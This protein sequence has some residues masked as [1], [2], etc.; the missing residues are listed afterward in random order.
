MYAILAPPEYKKIINHVLESDKNIVYERYGLVELRDVIKEISRL[1]IEVLII[2]SA[3]ASE[4]EIIDS[5]KRIKVIRPHLRIVLIAPDTKPGDSLVASLVAKGV[6]DILTPSRN[7]T[8]KNIEEQLNL[9]LSKCKSTYA[10][11]VRWDTSITPTNRAKITPFPVK[12]AIV[13]NMSNRAGSTFVATTLAANISA[14]NIVPAVVE[15]PTKP[16]LFSALGL[17]LLDKKQGTKFY[18][19]PH[20]IADGQIAGVGHE[21]YYEDIIWLVPDNRLIQIKDWDYPK[22]LRLLHSTRRAGVLIV[23]AGS[24]WGHESIKGLIT[25]ADVIIAVLDPL[26]TQ[27]TSAKGNIK[28]ML[29]Y[30]EKGLEVLFVANK[31]DSCIP[32]K[33]F[34]QIANIEPEIYIPAV[35]YS[36]VYQAGYDCTLVYSITTVKSELHLPISKL[37]NYLLPA[38]FINENKTKKYSLIKW[39]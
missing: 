19:Y 16:Y 31:W 18:S 28:R 10:D 3:I 26:P 37:A 27:T 32:K 9:M 22:M 12:M 7:D 6:Y 5:V 8:D 23:D 2:H 15:M 25:N 39:R 33:D 21:T 30:K 4:L 36:S 14:Y 34:I 1:N 13:V 24:E 11:A 35:D 38:Q 20:I 29:D 17:A